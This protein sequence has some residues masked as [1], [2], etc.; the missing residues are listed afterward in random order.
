MLLRQV[1]VALV[2]GLWPTLAWANPVNMER[3]A[4]T[5]DTRGWSASLDLSGG[6]KEGNVVK[7]EVSFGGG[8]QHRTFHPHLDTTRPAF[9][10]DRWI[11]SS[12]LA[13][14]KFSGRKV[15]DNGFMHIRYT[16]MFVRRVGA[17]TFLQSQYN[18][19][20]N[21]RSRL[22]AGGGARFDVVH[23]NLFGLWGGTGYMGEYEVNA[24]EG[25]TPS[26][27]DDCSEFTP[28]PHPAEVINHRWTSYVSM[29]LDLLDERLLLSST[30]Y[31]QPRFDDV[32]D[33]RINT[34]FQ[35]EA[36]VGSV[37]S[38]G[39]DFEVR[40]DSRPPR[41]VIKTDISFSGFLRF[42]FG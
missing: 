32:T 15:T 23:R 24:I 33:I 42:R 19:F 34:G 41:T 2:L 38:L 22:L 7:R 3:I 39:S 9:F 35:L 36:K 16:R 5:S 25:C 28:D 8:V 20:T 26:D 10:R 14:V 40:Y 17:E 18:E 30:T 13:L 4:T 1:S 27:D 31:V 11:L 29:R 12:N 6:V 21:L 37:F